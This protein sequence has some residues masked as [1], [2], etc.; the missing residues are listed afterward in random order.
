MN[1]LDIENILRS[2]SQPSVP[3]GLRERLFAQ[4][5]HGPRSGSDRARLSTESSVG[6]LR[7]WWPALAP[8]LVS[9]VCATVF[10]LR[11]AEIHSLKAEIEAQP[12]VGQTSTTPTRP[13]PQDSPSGTGA[14]TAEEAEIARLKTLAARLNTEVAQLEQMRRQNVELRNQLTALSASAFTSEETKALE[15]ARERALSVQCVNNLKQLGL[16]VKM[17]STDHGEI[18]P[19]NVQ[20]LSAYVGSFMKIFICPAEPQRQAASD[21]NSLTPANCSYEYLAASTPDNEANR[22]CV[23]FRC[24]IHG[25]IGL[26]DGSVQSSLAKKHPELLMQRDG[27]LYLQQGA[28]SPDAG[29]SASKGTPNQ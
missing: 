29:P 28:L 23:L 12:R 26:I 2:A 19:P 21:A 6:W 4:A 20:S 27:R 10:T 24:P 13:K 14:T 1:T 15:D 9:L 16:A 22:D 25:H 7:R 8:G 11:Q 5:P 18:T 3:A 17:W